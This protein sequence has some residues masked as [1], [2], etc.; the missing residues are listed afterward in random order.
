MVKSSVAFD[1][2]SLLPRY[3][4]GPSDLHLIWLV[5]AVKSSAFICELWSVQ[6]VL[7]SVPRI[8]RGY[9]Q[10]GCDRS[11][12]K[13]EPVSRKELLRKQL[14]ASKQIRR[15]KRRRDLVAVVCMEVWFSGRS[16]TFP[17]GKSLLL[18]YEQDLKTTRPWPTPSQDVVG[19]WRVLIADGQ[20][21]LRNTWSN[22]QCVSTRS[23]YYR[24]IYCARV[25]TQLDLNTLRCCLGSCPDRP[26]SDGK[27]QPQFIPRQ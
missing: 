8:T 14:I 1:S 11:H 2:E 18:N 23:Q 15:P 12:T 7:R 4:L 24:G 25:S 17:M 19:F 6:F 10:T 3:V 9:F 16:W 26:A 5:F 13:F 20:F 22:L 27:T 21:T